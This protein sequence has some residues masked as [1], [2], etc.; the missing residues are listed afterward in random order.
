[1]QV[2]D[3]RGAEL[4]VVDRKELSRRGASTALPCCPARIH[5]RA[6]L[7]AFRGSFANKGGVAEGAGVGDVGGRFVSRQ[8]RGTVAEEMRRLSNA[9]LDLKTGRFDALGHQCLCCSHDT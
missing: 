9:R 4:V 6:V 7:A 1:M 8:H 3:L 2:S 5:A